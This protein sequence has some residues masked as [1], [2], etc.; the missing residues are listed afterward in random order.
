MTQKTY[1]L[2]ELKNFQGN[3]SYSFLLE[4]A[5]RIETAV[6]N[7]M[8]ENDFEKLMYVDH[9]VMSET[10]VTLTFGKWNEET[11]EYDEVQK[12][13]TY[14]EKPKNF[15][16]F[17]TKT[18]YENGKL[19]MY[20]CDESDIPCLVINEEETVLYRKPSHP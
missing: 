8:W 17:M 14:L 11:K 13:I 20:I 12:A 7:L 5:K 19:K 6:N 1:T 3:D 18:Y 10:S 15:G 2:A 9:P 4:E 16:D